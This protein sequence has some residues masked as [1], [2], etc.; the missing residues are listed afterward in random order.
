VE[1]GGR[2]QRAAARV[3]GCGAAW[4]G[5][6]AGPSPSGGGA[7][8]LKHWQARAGLQARSGLKE[9]KGKKRKRLFFLFKRV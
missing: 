5:R 8:G 1:A 2:G 4:V 3:L 7:R 9:R 6:G